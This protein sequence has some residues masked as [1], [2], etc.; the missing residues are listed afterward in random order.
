MA[1]FRQRVDQVTSSFIANRRSIRLAA[2]SCASTS[3]RR[4][5]E[6]QNGVAITI[7]G[8][9]VGRANNRDGVVLACQLPIGEAPRRGGK[10]MNSDLTNV[11]RPA[12]HSADGKVR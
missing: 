8:A 5:R 2:S 7:D 1:R 6:P 3:P 11:I 12:E 9:S 10:I 4:L